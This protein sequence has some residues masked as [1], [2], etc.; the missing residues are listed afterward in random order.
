MLTKTLTKMVD[1]Y[2]PV[3]YIY[4]IFYS[5]GGDGLC[6]IPNYGSGKPH[7]SS[8][9]GDLKASNLGSSGDYNGF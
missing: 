5:G 7:K 8:L 6:C 9:N 3:A 2:D 4:K 1:G